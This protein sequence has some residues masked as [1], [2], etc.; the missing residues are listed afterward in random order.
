MIQ[1]DVSRI[2]NNPGEEQHLGLDFQM[3]PV[4]AGV[5]RIF[6]NTPLRLD[7]LLVNDGGLLKLAGNIEGN[8]KLACSRCLELFDMPVKEEISEIY[9]NQSLPDIEP[10]EEWVPFKGDNLDITPE[11]IKALVSSLPMKLLCREDCRGLCQKCGA[12]LN[13]SACSCIK[14]EID[15][16]LLVLKQLLEKK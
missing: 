5:D 9:Y 16:R 4:Q 11:V 15:A 1:L 14:D 12:N 3:Q 13:L 10:C 7:I 6:F 8:I 2:K